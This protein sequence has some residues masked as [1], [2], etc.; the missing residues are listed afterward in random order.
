MNVPEEAIFE[1]AADL[2]RWPTFL[3]HYRYIRYYEKGPDRNV[4]K[5]A[6]SRGFVPIAWVSEQLIDRPHR[7]IRFKHLK[8]WTK[9][10]EV[11]WRFQTLPGGVKVEI[12]HD[13]A[14]RISILAPLAELIIGSVFIGPIAT[15]TLR[16]MKAHL[17]K[18]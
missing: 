15:R 3:P 13:L 12:V 8:A 4:V 7:Q 17:E 10:M 9:G 14:F 18:R 5:M 16:H 6:A 1:T 11:I 2:E